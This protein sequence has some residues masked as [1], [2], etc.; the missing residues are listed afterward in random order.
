VRKSLAVGLGL[1]LVGG[2]V[3]AQR[4]LITTVAGNGKPGYSG[5]GGPATG[6]Q[7]DSPLGVG[8][9][10][11]GNVYIADS[12]NNVIRKVSAAT[13]VI[14][15]VAG[16]GKPGYT[17][18]GGLATS[19]QLTPAG[20]AVDAA[21]DIYIADS[22]NNV[23]REVMAATGVITT[24]AGNGTAGY[25]GDGGPAIN[26]ALFYPSFV[27]LDAAGNLF[28]VDAG[29]G[30]IRK[31]AAG[32]GV[33]TTVAG[34]GSDYQDPPDGVPA[35]SAF[36]KPGA[37]AVDAAGN[38]YVSDATATGERG[39]LYL[40][41]PAATGILKTVATCADDTTLGP[42][43]A[44]A[45]FVAV[46]GSG[47]IFTTDCTFWYS[48][49]YVQAGPT[50]SSTLVAGTD[51]NGYSGDGG[52]A[53]N[54]YIFYPAGAAT[55]AA[56]DVYFADSGNHAIRVLVPVATHA[57]LSIASTHSGNFLLGQTGAT[58]SVVVSNN[59]LAGPTSGMVTVAETVPTGLTLV[60]MSGAGWNCSGAACVRSDA[61]NPGAS[62]PPITVTVN[63]AANAPLAVTNG[64]G[65]SGG[66][67]IAANA[68]DV[69]IIPT[70]PPPAPVLVSPANGTTGVLLA[71]A[72][73]WNATFGASSYDVYFGALT[74]PPLVTSTTGTSYAPATQLSPHTIYYWQIVAQNGAGSTSSATWFFTTG[75]AVAPLLFVPVTPC[76][77]ADTRNPGGPFGGPALA[78][79]STR[80][81]TISQ[82]GCDIPA[83]AQAYSLNV[84]VVP[85]GRSATSRCGQPDSL[86]LSSP[87]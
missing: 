80:S 34:G 33:I 21:G 57:L 9:D 48:A 36:L 55:D 70:G 73:T 53:T 45:K 11:S 56:G 58:Y 50:G 67:S 43:T 41:V 15:T 81:F 18:D 27:A 29:N 51:T 65:V 38:L 85:D 20:A 61:L 52:L 46:D 5:D 60:S 84:T 68:S 1:L 25:S 86:S 19:A 82:G 6:A 17:G 77:V 26:A 10:G 78:G 87:L 24:V 66:G 31:I 44:A 47:N 37:V 16:N 54:A 76:R 23:I 8:V 79:G 63:V 22:S 69:T 12:G 39:S 49:I 4:Y 83:T 32:T 2:T 72:L 75:T 64:V 14:T 40:E 3:W 35:T 71:P 42:P 74:T 7:L 28:I 59:A 30:R 62:Y 13:G